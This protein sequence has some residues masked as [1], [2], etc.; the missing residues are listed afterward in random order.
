MPLAKVTLAGSA[1]AKSELQ[2]LKPLL[3]LPASPQAHLL[4]VLAGCPSFYL[5]FFLSLGLR[6]LA[7]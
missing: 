1:E 6:I 3:W 4:W 2:A 5:A 7:S